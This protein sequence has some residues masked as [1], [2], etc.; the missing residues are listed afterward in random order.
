MVCMLWGMLLGGPQEP[1]ALARPVEALAVPAGTVT[2][3]AWL[4]TT[5]PA[6][7]QTRLRMEIVGDAYHQRME[8]HEGSA[9]SDPETAMVRTPLLLVE[10]H[11]TRTG[12]LEWLSARGPA[13]A[14]ARL[15]GLRTWL[16][17]RTAS[18]ADIDA[19]VRQT[20]GTFGPTARE[21][22][23]SR[24]QQLAAIRREA[25]TIVR[26]AFEQTADLGPVWVV[27][28][29]AATRAYRAVFEPWS[30]ALIAVSPQ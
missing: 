26:T 21:A 22:V 4:L 5:Y 9:S 24:A 6:L 1:V 11:F 17:T 20:G 7:A 30:G 2:A 14:T 10:A 12:A 23:L 19:E 13:V 15:D 25:G 29:Q 3:Q 28:V 8:V 16:V 27:E 18:E